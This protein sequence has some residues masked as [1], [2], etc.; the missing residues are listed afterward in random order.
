MTQ[1]FLGLGSNMGEKAE[2]IA[3]AINFLQEKIIN[4]SAA[5]LYDSKAWGVTDQPD[6]INT[7]VRGETELSP[8]ELLTF[9]KAV[10]QRVGRIER[11][12][13]GPREID[14]DILFYGDQIYQR[15]KLQIPHAGVQDRDS[16][17]VPMCDLAPNHMHP[18]SHQTMAQLLAVLPAEL[19]SITGHH[20]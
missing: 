12:H 9:V 6:F 2:N 7:A 18:V 10:E 16:V 17:L 19:R 14:I 15:E 8:E 20:N 1:I 11:Y 3:K 4:V 5:P 13:W